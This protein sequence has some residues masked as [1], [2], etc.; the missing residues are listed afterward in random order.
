MAQTQETILLQV[1]VAANTTRLTELRK[2]LLANQ[3][4]LAKYNQA[5]KVGR[6]SLDELAV[7]EQRLKADSANLNQEIRALTK[8]NDAQVKAS[9]AGAGSIEQ[10]R[11]QLALGTA[12]YNKLSQAERDNTDAGQKLQANNKSLSDNLKVLE[13]AIGD[14]RRNVGNYSAAIDPLIAQLVKLQEVQKALPAGSAAAAEGQKQ[15]G[16]QLKAVNDAAAAQGKTLE[17]TKNEIKVYGEAV[18]P[19][20]A[21][22][23]ALEAEQ[24]KIAVSAGK[25]SKAYTEV[26][27][28]IGAARKEIEKVAPATALTASSSEK[29]AAGLD[30]LSGI[31][32]KLPGPLGQTV[33]GLAETGKGLL[34][35]TKAALAFI[36]TPLG[37][38]LAIITAAFFALKEAFT[39]TDEGQ[40]NLAAGMAAL[41]G[42]FNVLEGV[43]ISVGKG[44]ILLFTEPKKAAGELLDFLESQLINRVKAFGVVFDAIRNGDFKQLTNGTLQLATGVENVVGK[45]QA[46]TA[47]LKRAGAAAYDISRAKDQLEDRE[48]AA[49]AL[50]EKQRQQ[51]ERLVLTAKD[52]NLTEAQ[53]LRNLDEAGRL[54]TAVLNRTKGIEEERLRILQLEN[55]ERSKTGKLQDDERRAQEEQ[56]AKVLQLQGDYDKEQQVIENRR[57][58]LQQQEAASRLARAKAA[59][60]AAQK[61]REDAVRAQITQQEILLL[62]VQKGSAAEL[63][64][65]QRLIQLAA[66]L[67]LTAARKTSAEKQLIQAKANVAMK[68]LQDDFNQKEVENARKAT[69][70]TI[71][72]REREYSEAKQQ[73]DDYIGAKRAAIEQDYAK[74]LLSENQYQKALNVLEKAG[75][76]AE[77]V[78][79]R[80]YGQKQG[81]IEKR[82]ADNEIKE[83]QRVGREKKKIKEAELEIANAALQAGIQGSDAVIEAFGKESDAGRAALVVK[84]TLAIAEIGIGLEK[85]LAANAEAGAKISAEAPPATVPLGIAYTIATD[86]LAIVGAAASGAKILGFNTGGLVPG[87]GSTDTVPAMLTPGE[88]VMNK[89]AST[90][91]APVL[92]YLNSMSGGVN[93]AP[94]FT[95]RQA[96]QS[97]GGL[98]ARNVGGSVFPSA[99]EIGAAVAKNVPTTIGVD[100]INRAQNQKARARAVTTLG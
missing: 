66:D 86:A 63:A 93:F 82:Q 16:F 55:A 18:R 72:E 10:L 94:G 15:I 33:G 54:E 32:G 80:D 53:R 31:A 36:A 75:L 99:A 95:P 41:K 77:L 20:V 97:D 89:T 8:A 35:A 98:T 17:Q 30:K 84:K 81:A 49:V 96:G 12:E 92:S 51:A 70:A 26:G 23:V 44:L 76:D 88:V 64:V 29:A 1:D 19:A 43:V 61:R 69:E 38:F 74:G 40:E 47:E 11:A 73:L 37:A 56:Q 67:E 21:S 71:K 6:I 58:I 45:A 34:T 100:T 48:I 79:A 9:Q 27:F 57:S 28:K 91:F 42:I 65:R 13:G 62:E 52:R 4:S 7:A 68:Q 25:E 24:E 46:L 3:E 39:A 50:N 90:Q 22:L 5:A 59:S 83:A 87:T 14:T 60:E 2:E 78:N 85:Q